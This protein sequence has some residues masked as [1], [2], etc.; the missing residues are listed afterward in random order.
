MAAE[1]AGL[2]FVGVAAQMQQFTE[3]ISSS[4]KDLRVLERSFVEFEVGFFSAS[5]SEWSNSKQFVRDACSPLLRCSLRSAVGN[6][7]SEWLSVSIFIL[8]RVQVQLLLWSSLLFFFNPGV[9]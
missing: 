4:E 6:V 3:N 1:G 8:S 2:D 7:C 9:Q 5:L